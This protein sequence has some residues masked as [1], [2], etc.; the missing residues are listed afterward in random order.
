MIPSNLDIKYSDSQ[1]IDSQTSFGATE[2]EFHICL[3]M[4]NSILEG[5]RDGSIKYYKIE[6][7]CR[8]QEFIY[9]SSH[10]TLT[11]MYDNRG[12]SFIVHK[13]GVQINMNGNW[14]QF[15]SYDPREFGVHRTYPF[16]ALY[17]MK[18]C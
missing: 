14:F 9:Y 11:S 8:G 2:E 10:P 17:I 1:G 4:A 16:W 15:S 5:M 6:E 18:R 13:S 12:I 3:Y 7:E